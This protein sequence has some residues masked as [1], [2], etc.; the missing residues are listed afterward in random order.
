MYNMLQTQ[1]LNIYTYFVLPT[2]IIIFHLSTIM[3][4]GYNELVLIGTFFGFIITGLYCTYNNVHFVLIK[5][6]T[7]NEIPVTI[8]N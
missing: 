8:F 7:E 3:N 2:S 5:D 4:F 6:R 1:I